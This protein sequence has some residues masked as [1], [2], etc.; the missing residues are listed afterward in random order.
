LN[1]KKILSIFSALYFFKNRM[2]SNPCTS[3]VDWPETH[4]RHLQSLTIWPNKYLPSKSSIVRRLNHSIHHIL[5][6]ENPCPSMVRSLGFPIIHNASDH[7]C[8]PTLND[9]QSPLFVMATN[10]CL[11]SHSTC[12]IKRCFDYNSRYR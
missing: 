3:L 12:C 1:F 9:Y 10:G 4:S 5:T 2:N 8:Y 6:K 7:Q 11:G